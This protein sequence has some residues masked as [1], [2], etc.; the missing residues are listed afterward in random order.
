M[1]VSNMDQI[2][3]KSIHWKSRWYMQKD[4]CPE[5]SIWNYRYYTA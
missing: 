5:T 3:R 1:D 4:S 2:S